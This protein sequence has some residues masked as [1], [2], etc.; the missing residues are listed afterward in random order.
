MVAFC[1]AV[2]ALEQEGH[3]ALPQRPIAGGAQCSHAAG[4]SCTGHL[5][6]AVV[7]LNGAV[8]VE[9]S[10]QHS[11]SKAPALLDCQVQHLCPS[12]VNTRNH[13][14]SVTCPAVVSAGRSGAQRLGSSA[15]GGGEGTRGGAACSTQGQETSAA[16][17]RG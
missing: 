7:C 10:Q 15:E 5:S 17:R 2:S 14:A 6:S 3:I 8:L 11:A 1:K 4:L 9:I 12:P 13:R 16:A